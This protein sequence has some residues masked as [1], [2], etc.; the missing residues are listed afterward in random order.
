M[1]G[2]QSQCTGSRPNASSAPYTAPVITQAIRPPATPTA[3]AP[4]RPA[5]PSGGWIGTGKSGA[6]AMCPPSASAMRT[7]AAVAAAAAAGTIDRGLHSNS[8]SSTAS[9]VA[10]TGVPNTPV[11]PPA[12]PATSSVLRSVDERRTSWATSEPSAPPVRMIGPSAPKGP[13]LPMLITLETGLSTARRGLTRLPRTRMFS[14]ASGMPWPRIAS[15]PKRAMNP[16]TR[17]P[18]TG[19]ST[20]AGPSCA[21]AGETSSVLRRPK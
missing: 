14:I 17:P 19:I 11:M 6:G 1:A 2:H 20:L 10:A 21:S 9:R 15:D 8:S 3:S 12:A 16:T 7:A 5:S 13:P 4:S 18:A